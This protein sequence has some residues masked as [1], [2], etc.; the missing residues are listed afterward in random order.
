MTIKLFRMLCASSWIFLIFIQRAASQ[1]TR[2]VLDLE[3]IALIFDFPRSELTITNYLNKEVFIYTK[4]D[5]IEEQEGTLPPVNPK[6]IYQCYLISS[7]TPNA[8]LPI[9]ITVSKRDAYITPYVEKFIAEISTLPDLPIS[10]QGR[11][12][13]GKFDLS[14]ASSAILY[15][16]EIRVP[17]HPKQIIK[18]GDTWTKLD[19][20]PKYHP[21][22]V[23]IIQ[24]SSSGV[25]IRIAVYEC[26]YDSEPLVK[27]P[28]GEKYFAAF[29]TSE[30]YPKEPPKEPRKEVPILRIFKGRFQ[31]VSE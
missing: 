1:N 31:V 6:S 21:A 25:D 9:T 15:R 17:A 12:P 18:K 13:F 3:K 19:E 30:A 24:D 27:V 7:K 23:S 22:A 14:G 4:K 5:S 29:D 28:G 11:L 16:E 2:E 10:Q 26:L 8:F 20:Y